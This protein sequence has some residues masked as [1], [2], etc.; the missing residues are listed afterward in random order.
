MSYRSRDRVPVG[1][2]GE[3]GRG[4]VGTAAPAGRL[5]PLVRASAVGY[6]ILGV[7]VG[8]VAFSLAPW[9]LLLLVFAFVAVLVA[10]FLHLMAEGLATIE[11]DAS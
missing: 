2:S 7:I 8:A 1:V 3:V 11:E 6:L 9:G 4:T 10:F 5:S